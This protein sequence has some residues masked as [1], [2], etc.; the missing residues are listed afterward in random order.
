MS[1]N[2]LTYKNLKTNQ[3]SPFARKHRFVFNALQD[4]PEVY[5]ICDELL[6]R[7]LHEE[8][9]NMSENDESADA[10]AS[11]QMSSNGGFGGSA[12]IKEPLTP[13]KRFRGNFSLNQDSRKF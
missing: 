6:R 10:R 3:R 8:K 9:D 12:N 4:Q 2:L 7:K 5:T 11:R 1:R 13:N